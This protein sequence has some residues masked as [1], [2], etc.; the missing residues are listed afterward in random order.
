MKSISKALAAIRDPALSGVLWLSVGLTALLLGALGAGGYF[1]LQELPH[2]KQGWLNTLVEI[3]SGAGMVVGL[4]LLAYPVASLVIGIFLDDVAAKVETRDFPSDPPGR[5]LGIWPS[6]TTAVS[7]LGAVVG[8]NLLAL[9]V[10]LLVPGANI[11]LFLLVNGYLM[12][13][14]YFELVA[15]RHLGPDEARRLRRKNGFRVYLA[16][17]VIAVALSIP[18]LNLVAPIFGT[19]LM[20]HVFKALAPAA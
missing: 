16:G 9:P 5:S 1:A 2:F 14:E 13:R 7:F 10:Y 18:V 8:L 17:V 12:G 15:F 11:V 3:L 4:I 19:A 6:L 20:V